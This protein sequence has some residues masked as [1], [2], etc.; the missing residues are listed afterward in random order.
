MLKN[1]LEL[2]APCYNVIIS[3]DYIMSEDLVKK[4]LERGVEEV[5][6]KAHLGKALRSKK[7]LRVKLGIDPTAPDLHLGHTVVL[8]K[9]RQFQDAGHK[10]VL[11]IGDF[12]ALIGDPSGR[13]EGRPQLTEADIAKNMK[14]YL[15]EAGKV[16]DMKK[17]E[18]RYNSE[19]Y[20]DKGVGFLFELASRFTVART[21][22][23]DDFQKRLKAK[24]DISMLEV[25]YP[26]L[27][28][29]D[30]VAVKADVEL[31]G[32]DQK[33]NLL[34][35]RRVQRRYGLPE[36]DILTTPL[37]EGTDGVKKM[38]KSLG[39]YIALSEK[40]KDT[41]AKLM[42]VPDD[43]MYK[44][45]TLLTDWSGERL[46]QL[47]KDRLHPA[48][49]KHSPKEW[50]QMLAKEIV[51]MYHGQSAAKKAQ[52][53][54]EKVFQKGGLPEDVEEVKLAGKKL[55]AVDVLVQTKLAASRSEAR[56]VV[57]QGGMQ[58]NDK[59]VSDPES[60]L[61]LTEG[62][63]IRRGKRRFVRII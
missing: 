28:G 57:E 11:I 61:T 12:T 22:E 21:L 4:I 37:I 42:S 35:G 39:N 45:A 55:K 34:A 41:Y 23:R 2:S 3:L 25:L 8:R 56:R 32:T 33:F 46:E 6:V 63:V 16:L 60:L 15:E 10:A 30:S 29:Y 31:G 50:K 62:A 40:P 59:V 51:G 36:Q 1:E 47:N 24:R 20:K 44:Y 38:S 18:I 7:E 48:D 19:W 27:Q 54:F 9:L 17:A 14:N 53:E 58:L 13:S 5:I 49:A 26:L 52:S 43:L